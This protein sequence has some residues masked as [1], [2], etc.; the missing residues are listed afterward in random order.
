MGNSETADAIINYFIEQLHTKNI[1]Q[2]SVMEITQGVGISRVTFYNYF[3]SKE[4]IIET[5]LEE[6]LIG[7]DQLQ[8]ENL[9]FLDNV[10]MAN[11]EEIKE[12]LYPNTLGIL[13]FFKDNKKYIEAL[14]KSTD[15]VHFMDILHATYYNHFLVAIPEFLSKKFEEDTL[16]SYALYMTSGVKTITEEWFFHDFT[17]NPETVANRILDMLAPSLSELYNR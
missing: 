9:P 15:I 7:F 17:E 1:D 10:D 13:L 6:L 14:L 3:K 2:I 11:P 12:I 5:I 16:K 4:D 8:K